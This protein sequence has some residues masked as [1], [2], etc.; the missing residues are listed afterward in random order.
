MKRA[1]Y[2]SDVTNVNR[3]DDVIG[4]RVEADRP[5][6]RVDFYLPTASAKRS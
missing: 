6:H 5:A 4:F 2:L 1:V 3:L